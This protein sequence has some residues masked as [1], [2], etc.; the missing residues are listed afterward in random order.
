[1][2]LLWQK[3]LDRNYT[4]SINLQSELNND[5]QLLSLNQQQHLGQ[6]L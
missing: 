5:S 1:M 3:A 2:D 4:S 6:Q